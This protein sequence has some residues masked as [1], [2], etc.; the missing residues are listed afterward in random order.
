M[1]LL[2]HYGT[3]NCPYVPKSRLRD[4]MMKIHV[5]PFK[6]GEMQSAKYRWLNLLPSDQML[7]TIDFRPVKKL[8]S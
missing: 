7:S 3:L 8:L 4:P 5:S 1:P 6:S 2:I